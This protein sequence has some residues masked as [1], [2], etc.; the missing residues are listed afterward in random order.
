MIWRSGSSVFVLTAAGALSATLSGEQ[1]PVSSIHLTPGTGESGMAASL[2]I[3][4]QNSVNFAPLMVTLQ[5]AVTG[6]GITA[7]AADAYDPQ[8]HELDWVWSFYKVGEPEWGITPYSA[9]QQGFS[10][11]YIQGLS[12]EKRTG[13]IFREPGTYE[14]LV[15]CIRRSDGARATSSVTTLTVDDPNAVFTEAQTFVVASDGV[16]TGAPANGGK[17]YTTFSAAWNAAQGV[18][19]RIRILVKRGT[20]GYSGIN[21]TGQTPAATTILFGVWGSGA[22][23]VFTSGSLFNTAFSGRDFRYSNWRF[24]GTWNGA[25]NTGSNYT[26]I[27]HL[28][29]TNGVYTV[30]DMDCEDIGGNAFQVTGDNGAGNRQGFINCSHVGFNGCM[31]INGVGQSA[32]AIGCRVQP[33]ADAWVM[34][35]SGQGGGFGLRFNA[36]RW[37]AEVRQC[38][39]FNRLS[40]NF[41]DPVFYQQMVRLHAEGVVG[42]TYLNVTNCKFEGSGIEIYRPAGGGFDIFPVTQNVRNCH[43]VGSHS[44]VDGLFRTSAAGLQIQSCVWVNP[45]SRPSTRSSGFRLLNYVQ[46]LDVG[47]T[48]SGSRSNPIKIFNNTFLSFYDAA[49]PAIISLAAGFGGATQTIQNNLFHAPFASSGAANL[50]NFTGE[51][52]YTP[53]FIGYYAFDSTTIEPRTVTPTHVVELTG[54]TGTFNEG[55]TSANVTL[56]SPGTVTANVTV[57]QGSGAARRIWLHN[58]TGTI[59]NGATVTLSSGGSGTASGPMVAT[60]FTRMPVPDFAPGVDAGQPFSRV[61]MLGGLQTSAFR[62]AL[63]QAV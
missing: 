61:G 38:D 25:N 2:S 33:R 42:G 26:A 53:Q 19:G 44:Y 39:F 50:G 55:T 62:G 31:V 3:D 45:P 40:N 34:A 28:G 8:G 54:A 47:S 52:L 30:A 5:G 32:L 20:T 7:G 11:Q 48:V 17:T 29:H 21:S 56:T 58:V 13:M 10:G 57:V 37:L 46:M 9:P 15:T 4:W 12:Y 6:S 18:S 51:P 63:P 60:N 22:K 16:Y 41:S 59:A 49:A 27:L 24:T 35:N 36:S 1:P 14:I 23:P 43:V